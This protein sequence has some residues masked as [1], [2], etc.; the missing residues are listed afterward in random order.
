[1]LG[2]FYRDSDGSS[3]LETGPVDGSVKIISIKNIGKATLYGKGSKG[4]WTSRP[5]KLKPGARS[6]NTR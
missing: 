1:V 5:M 2:H 6:Y 4:E 3:R